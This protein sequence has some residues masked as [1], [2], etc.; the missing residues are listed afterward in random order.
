M[1]GTVS[2]D[3]SSVR[4]GRLLKARMQHPR[5]GLVDFLVRNISDG[6]LGGKCLDAVEPGDLVRIVLPNIPL[7]D[8]MIVWRVGDGF[9]MRLNTLLAPADVRRPGT[10]QPEAGGYEVPYLFRPPLECRRPGVRTNC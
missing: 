7:A 9:G 6:G 3:R 2:H 8:G 4:E 1:N 5:L 10:C